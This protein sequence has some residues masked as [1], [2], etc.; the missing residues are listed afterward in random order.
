MR[1][2]LFLALSITI[3]VQSAPV[4]AQ[5]QVFPTV[6][7]RTLNKDKITV[8][9]DF[10]AARNIMLLSFGRDMQESVDAWDAVLVTVREASDAV[11]VY[12]AP[13]I[14][15]PNGIVR[16]FINGGFRGIYKDKGIRDRVVILYIDEDE[17]FSALNISEEDKQ[18]PLVMVTDQQGV[19]I[20]RVSG[21]ADAANVAQVVA[22]LT[23]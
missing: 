13:L 22:L 16:G 7:A 19:I 8:P 6:K 23:P 11:Q 3:G 4:V 14:P 5:D 2:L 15:K 1:A 20:G 17:V 12:N 18:H 21:L 9:A 10:T